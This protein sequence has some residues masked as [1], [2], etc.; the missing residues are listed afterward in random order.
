MAIRLWLFALCGLVVAMVLVGGA[1]RLTDSGLSI[2]EWRPITGAVPPLSEAE[3]LKEFEKYQRIP[4][5]QHVN[6][7]MSLAAFKTIYWW[8][9]GHRFLGRLL[10]L[11]FLIP[12]CFFLVR[13]EISARLVWKLIVVFALGGAQGALGWWMV[14]SGLSERIDVSQYRLAAHLGLAILLLVAMFW[15]GLDMR[16]GVAQERAPI[17]RSL[18]IGA[19]IMS[20]LVYLQIILGAFVA[21]LRAG[22][23]Y[24]TWP[25]MEGRFIPEAYFGDEPRWTDLFDR[26]AAAQFN[27][28][29]GAYVLLCA[30]FVFF[31]QSRK[32]PHANAG[33]AILAFTLAQAILGVATVLT[34]APIGLSLAHQFCAI[35]LLLYFVFVFH[36]LTSSMSITRGSSSSGSA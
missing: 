2:T 24:N 8:E 35:A 14:Q 17:N 9:W 7:G 6:A 16:R 19:G 4:E 3:W 31:L 21:G 5:Y 23:V 22:R 36:G 11:A 33:R 15:I 29:I 26:A 25:L 1:T 18:A 30:A 34:A 27:H 10:G 20:V 28:R 13:R 32:T 12:F